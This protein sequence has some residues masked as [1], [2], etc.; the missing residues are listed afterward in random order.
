M[1]M[2][3]LQVNFDSLRLSIRSIIGSKRPLYGDVETKSDFEADSDFGANSEY[4]ADIDS[5]AD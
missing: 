4:G 3:R 5:G 1:R 2:D